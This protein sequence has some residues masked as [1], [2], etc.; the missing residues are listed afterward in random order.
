MIDYERLGAMDAAFLDLEDDNHHMHVG[1]V[2]IFDA[3]PLRREGG[4]IDIER[5]R[6]TIESRLHLVPR[7]RQRLA[8]IP[9]ERL[10]IWV[11]DER[12]RLSYH[13]RHASL[14]RPGD[15]RELKR[16]VGRIMSQPLDRSR[17]LW[18]MW[19]IEGLAG[20]RFALVS[21]NHHCMVD[22]VSAADVMAA[23]LQPTPDTAI[24]PPHPWAPRSHPSEARLLFDQLQRRA[25]QATT[26]WQAMRTAI[27]HPESAVR[28]LGQSFAGVLEAVAPALSPV[29][30]TPINVRVGPH[31]RFDWL[32]MDLRD[33][34]AVTRALG[35][36]INDL[37]LTITSGALREYFAQRGIAVNGL[38]IRAMV[39]VA[40]RTGE[41]RGHLGNRL[42]EIVVPIPVRVADPVARL[43]AVQR[44]TANL[45]RSRHAL[46][47]QVLTTVSE[48][49]VPSLL[50]QVVRL[51]SRAGA[52]NLVVTNVP[53]PQIP[54]YLCGAP[55]RTAYPVVPL[56]ENMGITVGLFSYNGGLFWGVNGDW[57]AMT[58][59]HEFQQAIES[60]FRSLQL[61]ADATARPRATPRPRRRPAPVVME[62]R[63]LRA[64]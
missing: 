51:A 11:D 55:M 64:S 19:L 12:F 26:A 53:G 2:M 48:W 27:N 47:A 44:T 21:K 54:L 35:G 57:E 45:K 23:I 61:A 29:S 10:P 25:T 17:P 7:F 38:E 13:V 37:V 24:V 34:K 39:P 32:N 36:T 22:G 41:E 20:D 58:D 15:D 46:G 5:I 43:R 62:T 31:R 40:L 28:T 52:C 8:Y 42:T 6:R 9:F 49:T 14:P 1:G 30:E 50:G 16:L 59:L 56:F 63:P 18:E 33:L 3:G 4:G 60:S